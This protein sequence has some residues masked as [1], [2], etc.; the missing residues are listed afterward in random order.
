M[1]SYK[2]TLF[3]L[4]HAAL[5]FLRNGSHSP[6]Q[7]VGSCIEPTLRSSQNLSNDRVTTILLC[8]TDSK[9]V[10][11][12]DGAPYNACLILYRHPVFKIY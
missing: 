5:S 6:N 9:H 1:S 12:K 11:K 7:I 4:S 10:K 3:R 2:V 8:K